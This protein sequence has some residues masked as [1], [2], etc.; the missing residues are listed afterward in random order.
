M[1]K[2]HLFSLLSHS[3]YHVSEN[4]DCFSLNASLYVS[5]DTNRYVLID[6][7][8]YLIVFVFYIL[9]QASSS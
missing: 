6:W 1:T 2:I 4:Q 8:T 5:L 9:L 3:D 7:F